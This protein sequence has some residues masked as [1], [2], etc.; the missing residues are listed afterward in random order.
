MNQLDT[1][2]EILF[3]LIEIDESLLIKRLKNLIS[4]TT[5]NAIKIRLYLLRDS[6]ILDDHHR[7]LAQRSKGGKLKKSEIRNFLK[8]RFNYSGYFADL[9][10]KTLLMFDIPQNGLKDIDDLREYFGSKPDHRK[11]HDS[12]SQNQKKAIAL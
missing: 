6:F 8:W 5:K 7:D 10:A 4:I 12:D 1:F 11:Y 2:P 3:S 9:F